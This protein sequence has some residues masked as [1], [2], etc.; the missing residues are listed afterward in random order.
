MVYNESSNPLAATGGYRN[1]FQALR[2]EPDSLVYG[3]AYP[4]AEVIQYGGWNAA[5]YA[6]TRGVPKR[7]AL[8]DLEDEEVISQINEQFMKFLAYII[9]GEGA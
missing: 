5:N 4:K 3:S 8:P 2:I 6:H 9:K 1:S 7:K